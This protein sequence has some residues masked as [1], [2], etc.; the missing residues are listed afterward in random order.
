[1]RASLFQPLAYIKKMM[2]NK[3]ASGERKL[4]KTPA[5][6]ESSGCL[7]KVN[8]LD[9]PLGYANA[10]RQNRA[11]AVKYSHTH[12]LLKIKIVPFLRI[13]DSGAVL[14]VFR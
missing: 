1:M 13:S 14:S 2:Y 8:P 11:S 6:A 4:R 7:A 3:E 12:L 9:R 10:L 5:L